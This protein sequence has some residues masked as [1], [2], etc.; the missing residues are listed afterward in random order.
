MASSWQEHEGAVIG[1]G[2]MLKNAA[3][4]ISGFSEMGLEPPASCRLYR[5][6]QLVQKIHDRR[7][8]ITLDGRVFL[9]QIA[10]SERTIIESLV[11]TQALKSHQ[12]YL[13]N[14]T[15]QKKLKILLSGAD[16]ASEDRNPLA[17]NTQFELMLYSIFLLG[18]AHVV[19]REPDVWVDTGSL[20][21]ALAAKRVS[22][23]KKLTKRLNDAQ[24]QIKKHG[25]PGI[26][27]ISID[28]IISKIHPP[29]LQTS[30][31]IRGQAFD[32]ITR[33]PF[34]PDYS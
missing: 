15:T 25:L 23:V 4:A 13:A 1:S 3:T 24:S 11:I 21:T 34:S 30:G 19:W 17:R 22:S 20:T 12:N 16:G 6:K 18:G 32:Q 31:A 29:A 2:R 10:E 14:Q 27:A 33:S 5:A 28:P 26:A 7:A 9:G 8:V